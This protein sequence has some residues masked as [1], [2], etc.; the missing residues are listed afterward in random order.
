MQRQPLPNA[1]S[2]LVE[3]GDPTNL[4]NSD[5]EKASSPLQKLQQ[6]WHWLEQ[7]HPT[8]PPT[9]ATAGAVPFFN[10]LDTTILNERHT[11][12]TF[13][14]SPF[15]VSFFG[16]ATFYHILAPVCSTTKQASW[17]LTAISSAV[18]SLASLPFLWAYFAGGGSVKSIRVLPHFA[19]VVVRFFQ[20]YLAA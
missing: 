14:S 11:I 10:A 2:D 12:T 20:A 8:L 18:M 5:P 13:M 3:L 6:C 9:M 19:V 7:I 1:A 16:L 4:P 15:F 17:I